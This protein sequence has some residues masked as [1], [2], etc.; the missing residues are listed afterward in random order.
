MILFGAGSSV[1]FGIP[2]MADFTKEFLETGKY[3]PDIVEVVKNAIAN[4]D[5]TIGL[6]LPFDLESLLSV[7][8][9]LAE[10]KPQK[11]ISVATVALL[12]RKKLTIKKAREKYKDG[13][14]STYA[15]LNEFVFNTC[16]RP[17]AR[18]RDVAR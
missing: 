4:S 12:L 13:A 3:D 11:P 2:G 9:D 5:Q 15:K 8:N 14:R 16:M 18:A 17:R 1:P 7:L 10:I 6:V